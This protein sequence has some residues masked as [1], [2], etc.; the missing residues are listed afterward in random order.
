MAQHRSSV[1]VVA[2]DLAWG[3]CL[4]RML[5]DLAFRVTLVDEAA[6]RVGYTELAHLLGDRCPKAIVWD[7]GIPWEEGWDLLH[8]F[9]SAT[10]SCVPRWIAVAD[11][12]DEVLAAVV[13]G[14]D[15]TLLEKPVDAEHLVGAIG[16]E[17][18]KP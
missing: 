17:T 9:R 18:P 7:L 1:V 12:R 11:D 4:S 15:L 13:P 14:V 2:L 16:L 6:V 3:A 5:T 10:A 8:E